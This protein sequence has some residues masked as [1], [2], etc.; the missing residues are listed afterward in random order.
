V[1]EEARC[2]FRPQPVGADDAGASVVPT[3]EHKGDLGLERLAQL[4]GHELAQ[5]RLGLRAVDDRDDLGAPR[6]LH[7]P[8][9]QLVATVSRRR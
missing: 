5:L 6:R 1:L 7:E 3:S 4:G 2:L 8:P 9:Q